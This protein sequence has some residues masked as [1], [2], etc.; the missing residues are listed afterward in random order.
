V[1]K[2]L[3]L[4]NYRCFKDHTLPLKAT[5]IIIGRNNAGKSTVVEALRLI[6]IVV[7]RYQAL[8]YHSPPPWLDAPRREYGV[9]PSLKGME[10]GFDSLFNQYDEPPSILT[11]H[12]S[13]KS[14]IT[15][16][17]G[18]EGQIHAVIRDSKG[19]VIQTKSQANILRLPRVE[20]MPQ[21]A[22]VAKS[23][24]VLSSEYVKS[25]ISSYLSPL[26][27]RNQ[28]NVYYELFPQ[29]KEITE[30]TWPGLQI[31]DLIGQ[32]AFPNS[33]L[34]LQV[35]NEDFVA[36]IGVMGHG[37]QMWLQTMWFLTRSEGAK[38]VILDEP[39][40]YMHP[41]LQRRLIR[42]LRRKFSQVII[43]T[44]SVEIMAEV[45]TDE[46][47]IIDRKRQKS[48]FTDNIPAVQKIIDHV[49]SVHNIHL[50]KLWHARKCLIVEGKDLKILN[51][52]HEILFPDSQESLSAI[53]NLSIGGWGGWN[54]AIGSSMLL[55]NTGGQTILTYCV[56]DSDYHTPE[57]IKNR[58]DE[59]KV[60]GVNL[61]I[62]KKKEIEN[63]CL[64]STAIQRYII[65]KAQSHTRIPT[66]EEIIEKLDSLANELKTETFDAI[67]M[68]IYS[69]NKQL[70]PSGANKVARKFLDKRWDTMDKRLSVVS[71]KKLFTGISKWSQDNYGVSFSPVTIART[72]HIEEIPKEMEIFINAVE[73]GISII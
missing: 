38:T 23:E 28:L 52:L 1:L 12:F 14:N 40:V 36:D 67:A 30:N 5:S 37:L 60:H 24:V 69:H 9:S 72:M 54:Y 8:S 4:Q 63:Y 17:L 70:G 50:A 57:S 15:I 20:I 33:P 2:E 47:L 49:G 21:V 71:G 65:S 10:I 62:W 59:A 35:R 41:D 46:I 55:K 39:D 51:E 27:F 61:Y 34:S 58:I 16:Y 73:K 42:F 11:A 56:L 29:F 7:S 26:H 19:N 45:E 32:G 64:A 3:R 31:R 25:A 53:P 68:E 13:N 44:H 43:A 22:P 48:R 18:S 6:S 66:S